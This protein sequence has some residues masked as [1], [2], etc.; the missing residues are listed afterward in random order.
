MQFNRSCLHRSADPNQVRDGL[1]TAGS[2]LTS[3]ADNLPPLP[4]VDRDAL[5][6]LIESGATFVENNSGNF[7]N[8][9]QSLLGNVNLK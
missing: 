2:T 1:S 9:F 8:L 5:G 7:Q 4:N 6:N 3:L